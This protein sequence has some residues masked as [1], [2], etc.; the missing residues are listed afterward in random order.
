MKLE[1]NLPNT[2]LGEEGQLASDIVNNK[3]KK[4][5]T[6][7]SP[8]ITTN[9]ND[10]IN[11]KAL[12]ASKDV[13]NFL[14]FH[15]RTNPLE[16]KKMAKVKPKLNKIQSFEI[17]SKTGNLMPTGNEHFLKAIVKQTKRRQLDNVCKPRKKYVI[18]GINA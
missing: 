3:E 14:T 9:E 11:G 12:T 5:Y 10:N 13:K 15:E 7:T 16:R 8:L 4:S 17:D 6:T 2:G 1:T 18:K